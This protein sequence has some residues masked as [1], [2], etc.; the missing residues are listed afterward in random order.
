MDIDFANYKTEISNGEC[1]VASARAAGVGGPGGRVSN[2]VVCRQEVRV[3][4][5]PVHPDGGHQVAG[6]VL[7]EPHP[8][9]LGAARVPA[10]RRGGRR[11][12]HALPAAQ[13]APH[14]P[15][16]RRARR[17]TYPFYTLSLSHMHDAL[18]NTA[19]KMS[20]LTGSKVHR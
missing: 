8:Y 12:A 9:V 5:V 13:G 19:L 6:A 17:G 2:P 1:G 15:H 11:T 18:V 10:A 4:E 3:P 14:T 7:R 16:R 20:I